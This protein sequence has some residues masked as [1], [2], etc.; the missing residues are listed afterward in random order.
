[1]RQNDENIRIQPFVLGRY[2]SS[3]QFGIQPAP[4]RPASDQ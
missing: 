3:A 4:Q 1:M 2:G